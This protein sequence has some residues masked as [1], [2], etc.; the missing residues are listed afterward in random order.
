MG[1]LGDISKGTKVL[2]LFLMLADIRVLSLLKFRP[3]LD[4]DSPFYSICIYS[5]G[6]DAVS[7]TTKLQPNSEVCHLS[8]SKFRVVY[9]KIFQKN[10]SLY[11]PL[12]VN[13]LFRHRYLLRE[14]IWQGF[15]QVCGVLGG[16]FS[17]NQ[18]FQSSGFIWHIWWQAFNEKIQTSCHEGKTSSWNGWQRVILFFFF[19]VMPTLLFMEDGQASSFCIRY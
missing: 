13:G 4:I 19:N 9:Y 15:T 11:A 17:I 7:S 12:K 2:Q 6:E 8:K 5:R 10:I 3:S 18:T 16:V 1:S 14:S